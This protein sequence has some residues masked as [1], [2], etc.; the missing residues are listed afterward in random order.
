MDPLA[1]YSDK[2]HFGRR[3]YRLFSD[4]VEVRHNDTLQSEG[5]T[6]LRLLDLNPDFER[7]AVRSNFFKSGLGMMLGSWM[8]YWAL[9]ELTRV[10]P[11]A[12][13]AGFFLALG[14]AGLFMFSVGLK[15]QRFVC[16]R[17][18]AGVPTL[19]IF[20]EGPKRAEFDA[21]IAELVAAI[22]ATKQT[23]N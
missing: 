1:T 18:L 19:T 7:A 15:K 17:T 21:F 5:E 9:I 22:R 13:F 8:V 11:F 14:F 16:F 6:T 3:S 23:G 20:K 10:D 4:R 2:S 12:M